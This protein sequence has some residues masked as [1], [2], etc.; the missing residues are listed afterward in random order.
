MWNFLEIFLQGPCRCPV[1]AQ[2]IFTGKQSE[3]LGK[4]S[5]GHHQMPCRCPVDDQPVALWEKTSTGHLWGIYRASVD[6]LQMPG[7]CPADSFPID[8]G[9]DWLESYTVTLLHDHN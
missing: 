9:T 5:T 2:P 6:E 1:D 4:T 7:R 3:F 8:Q